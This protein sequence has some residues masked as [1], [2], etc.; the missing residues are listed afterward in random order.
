MK[1]CVDGCENDAMYVSAALCQKHYFRKMRNGTTELVRK[2]KYRYTTSNGYQKIYEPH[3]DLAD[4]NGY[5]YEHRKVLYDKIG[6]G[7]CLCEMCGDEWSWEWIRVSH[8]DHI[9]E[10]RSDNRPENLRPLC[11]GCNTKRGMKE[12]HTR[13]NN[14]SISFNGKTMTAQEWARD[15]SVMVCGNTIIKRL[16]SGMSVEDALFSMKKTHNGNVSIDKRPR[17]TEH[18]HQRKNSISITIN[19][20]TKTA[21]EWSRDERCHVSDSSI[22]ARIKAG[23]NPSDA[24]LMKRC[25]LTDLRES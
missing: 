6:P 5:V 10:D 16:S 11:T 19:G 4:A 23:V 2:R 3:H 1:C 15:P 12:Q 22:R 24:V 9:N 14:H 20:E 7:N 13:S 21:A 17:K 8:V 18:K 25:T